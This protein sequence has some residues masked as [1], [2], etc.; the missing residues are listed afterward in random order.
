ML[1]DRHI[2]FDSEDGM[3]IDGAAFAAEL[4]QLDNMDKKAIQ[5]WI[6]C[7]GGSVMDGMN[8]YNAILKSKTPV[9]TYNMGIAASMGGVCFMA[10]RKRVMADYAKLMLHNPGGSDDRKQIDSMK[11]S[12]VTMLSAKSTVTAEDVSYLMDRTTWL[13]SSECFAKGFATDIQATN[14]HNRKRMPA[15][16]AARELWAIS[17]N[18]FKQENT[19]MKKVTAKLNLVDGASEDQ[20]LEA[21]KVIENK[22]ATVT[23]DAKIEADK[24][25][26]DLKEAQDKVAE[27]ET[28]LTTAEGELKTV[29]DA[30]EAAATAALNE[31]ATGMVTN[32]AKVGRIKNEAGVIAGWVKL[33]VTDFE[34][35]K[36]MI[37]DLPLNKTAP[38]LEQVENKLDKGVLPT[39]AMGLA[40]QNKLRREGKI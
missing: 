2:G 40:V 38:T 36:K 1:L 13:N 22:L 4:L 6:N 5:V 12:L 39:T 20:V 32:F 18:I 29:T 10:G 8:I 24:L 19:D 34:G 27:I 28:K 15:T 16:A 14:E 25:K 11:D 33:A 37:E 21:I 23:N 30:A 31:K 35:T 3:G 9:D 26:A 17:N 7:P